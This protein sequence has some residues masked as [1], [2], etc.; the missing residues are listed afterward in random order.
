MLNEIDKFRI[1][2]FQISGFALMMP[3]GKIF[4]EPWTLF[5]ELNTTGL[6]LYFIIT[7]ILE[8]IGICLILKSHDIL[9]DRKD[10]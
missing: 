3:F 4:L 5:K 7:S 2:V 1:Q 6:V 8:L 10:K 9:I